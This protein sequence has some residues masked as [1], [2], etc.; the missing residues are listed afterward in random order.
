M[1]KLPSDR[2]D[3]EVA[4]RDYYREVGELAIDRPMSRDVDLLE[5]AAAR[6]P[7][8]ALLPFAAAMAAC[9]VLC[10]ALLPVAMARLA[11]ND[12]GAN[13][14]ADVPSGW[15]VLAP[16]GE[17]FSVS[18]PGPAEKKTES[19]QTPVG[20]ASESVWTST[21]A[22]GVQ[23]MVVRVGLPAG[24]VANVAPSRVLDESMAQMLALITD[25]RV[26]SQSDITLSGHPGRVFVVA[27]ST[28]TAGGEFF[29]VGDDIYGVG[30]GGDAGKVDAGRTQSLFDSFR[31][32]R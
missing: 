22:A 14:A 31:I 27:S 32:T 17:G 9:L 6:R 20:L 1:T 19:I 11:G 5:G 21:D 30:F 28:V 26:A 3:L 15:V 2:G 29:V 16:A 24:S 23:F 25:G 7:R 12:D 18:M 10:V 8:F 13:A 4:L